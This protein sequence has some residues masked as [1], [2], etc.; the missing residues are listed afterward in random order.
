MTSRIQPPVRRRI[1]PFIAL[2]LVVAGC[3]GAPDSSQTLANPPTATP[4]ETARIQPSAE[5]SPSSGGATVEHCGAST[6]AQLAYDLPGTEAVEVTCGM[7]YKR[8]DGVEATLDLYLP[9]GTGPAARLPVVVFVHGNGGLADPL[10]PIEEHWKRDGYTNGLVAAASGWAGITFDYR[11]YNG[12]E[13]LE[14]A[15]Q[16]VLD[17]LAYLADRADELRLDSTR[18]CLWASSGGG[19]PAAWAAMRGEPRPRCVVTFSARLDG[20]SVSLIHADQPPFF[21]ARGRLDSYAY[22][23]SMRFVERA[24]AEGAQIVVEDHPGAHA[25]EQVAGPD[26][27]RIIE[28]ALEFLRT[29]LTGP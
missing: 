5:V 15:Q 6:F 3:S 9:P 18:I 22:G 24:T 16:D 1:S 26:S 13:Q 12:S 23:G 4:T 8:I 19:L 17:L 11:G 28:A 29:H 10:K 21:I 7:T 14:A 25:F 27:E 2:M 20:D